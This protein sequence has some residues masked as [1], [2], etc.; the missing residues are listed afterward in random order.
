MT[1]AEIRKRIVFSRKGP[2]CGL[3]IYSEAFGEFAGAYGLGA[4]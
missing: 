3:S 1:M 4:K 2:R